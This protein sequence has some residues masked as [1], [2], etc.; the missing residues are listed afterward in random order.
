MRIGRPLTQLTMTLL[1]ALPSA[2]AMGQEREE[3]QKAD[4]RR[5]AKTYFHFLAEE[6]DDG[7]DL[8]DLEKAFKCAEETV[9]GECE[10]ADDILEKVFEVRRHE[11]ADVL[12]F[13]R[14]S[15]ESDLFESSRPVLMW[16]R[17]NTPFVRGAEHI[18]VLAF[19]DTPFKLKA[20]LVPVHHRSGNPFSGFFSL[21]SV[22]AEPS[23]E[24]SKVS[25]TCFEW[26]R[27]TT[28]KAPRL[29]LGL[30]RLPTRIDTVNFLSLTRAVGEGDSNVCAKAYMP[31]ADGSGAKVEFPIK[32]VRA[33]TVHFSNSR[34]ARTTFALGLAGTFNTD[35]SSVDEPG[36][37]TAING[38]G[39]AKLFI[40]RPR[41]G[42]FLD[43]PGRS[44]SRSRRS[45]SFIAGTNLSGDVFDEILV[46]IGVGNIVGKVGLFV[47]A[48][49]LPGETDKDTGATIDAKW[50]PIFGFE[51]SF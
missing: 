15:D 38:Y 51:Y 8:I 45:V 31:K 29:F 3:G 5:E 41:L 36:T 23:I 47:G 49:R 43:Q 34:A 40:R 20:E 18:W 17:K 32:T 39:M 28:G 9:P 37:E 16:N 33:T 25:E 10:A 1:L 26:K 22:G 24:E 27:I 2:G 12:I 46:A 42:A 13:V 6:L 48:N 11:L 50:R 35:S 44:F 21:L 14:K 30:A 4:P 7:V 19:S